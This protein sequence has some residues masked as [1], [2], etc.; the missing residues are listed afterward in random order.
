MTQRSTLFLVRHGQSG[1]NA[2][3][4]IQGQSTDAQGLTHLGR[5]QSRIAARSLSDSGAEFIVSSDLTRAI[6]T[7]EPIA[8]TL[9]LPIELE[10]RL[11]ERSLGCAEGRPEVTMDQS[12]SGVLGRAVQDADA[13]PRNGESIRDLYTRV[14]EIIDDLLERAACKQLIAVTHG[15][16][17]RVAIAYISGIGPDEMQWNR[18]SNGSVFEVVESRGFKSVRY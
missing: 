8:R 16:V 3:G 10:P 14:S 7:A 6:E 18:I 2:S 13:R 4:L 15:G 5:D 12:E 17:I 1:W 9:G 11:R